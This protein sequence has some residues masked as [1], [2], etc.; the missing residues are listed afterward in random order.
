M[1]GDSNFV[2]KDRMK[3]PVGLEA[4]FVYATEGILVADSTGE[5]VKANPS[6]EKMFGYSK[7]E[8]LGKKVELLVPDKYMGH[9]AADRE[10]YQSKPKPRSMGIGM[11]LYGKRK[12]NT[13]FPL[14]I[15]LSPYTTD[16]ETF[17]IAFIIDITQRKAAEDKLKNYSIELEKQVQDR[18]MILREAI[19][20][21]QNTKEELNEALTKEKELNDLKSRFVSLVS[22]EFRTPLTGVLSSLSLVRQHG[23]LNNFDKQIKHIQRIKES[24]NGLTD[25]LNDMLS[26]S[27]LEEGKIAVTSEIIDVKEFVGGVATELQALS[28][29]KQTIAYAHTGSNQVFIDKKI[30]KHILFN[31]ISN[32]IKFSDEG[33]TIHVSSYATNENLKLVVKD[34]GIGISAE[35]QEHLF[36]RFFRAQ[37]ASN[38]QGT[39]L[40]LNIVGKYVEMLGGTIAFNSELNKGTA[41]IITLPNLKNN[42]QEHTDN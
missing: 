25:I 5:I 32:A 3:N 6:S 39:G 11:D 13:E 17:V 22:H 38:I 34:E 27:K 41:F 29:N 36:E 20:E 12:D 24:V 9:H 30:V 31:L 8:L 7:E 37:N 18:T 15:S 23:E 42:G 35:D 26:I 14:E 10:K 19:E 16:G 40:G 33:K 4:L 2:E 28:K 21:L 1:F